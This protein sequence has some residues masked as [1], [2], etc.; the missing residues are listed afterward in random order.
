VKKDARCPLRTDRGVLCG[1]GV[2]SRHPEPRQGGSGRLARTIESCNPQDWKYTRLQILQITP[3][4]RFRALI[5]EFLDAWHEHASE[6]T[7]QSAALALLTASMTTQQ[8]QEQQF[9]ELVW[10]GPESMG[11]SLRRTDQALLQVIDAAR[12][13]L[14]IV[15]FAVYRIP[16]ITQALVR[17]VERG[18][19]L[20]ICVEAP[21]P[22]GQR[23][24]Y[25]TIQALGEM[26][27]QCA[28]IYIWPREKRPVG[29]SG[30]VGSLHVKCA[31]ADER[32]LFVSSANLTEHAMSLNMELGVLIKGSSLP[33]TVAAH[34]E[35]L[36]EVGVLRGMDASSVG[37]SH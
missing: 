27:Q 13:S 5:G 11:I 16:A 29:P 8:Y 3:Q 32:L 12:H 7:P 33:G 36:M 4:P 14:L 23:M 26:V 17:A 25:D 9:V 35:R 37:N 31:V 24:A 2:H 20:R 30:R 6:V 10:T 15:S 19:R 28:E 1:W 18:V 21:E 22:S 34:F